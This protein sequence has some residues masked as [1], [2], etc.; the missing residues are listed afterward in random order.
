MSCLAGKVKWIEL[1][2]RKGTD[3]WDGAHF[4]SYLQ[5]NFEI[6]DSLILKLSNTINQKNTQIR[7]Q[8]RQ[9]KDSWEQMIGGDLEMCL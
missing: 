5:K 4:E 2:M 8:I 9:Q 6:V 1:M 3:D 7:L